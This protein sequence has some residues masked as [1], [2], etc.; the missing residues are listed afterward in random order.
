MEVEPT[1][2][3]FRKP[4]ST[5]DFILDYLRE[6]GQQYI[7]EMH[8]AYKKELDRLARENG[9]KRPYHKPRYHSFEMC[10]QLLAREGAIEFSGKEEESDNLRFIGWEFKP[11]RRF[12]RL[13]S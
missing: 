5:R 3:G 9:R 10:V 7:A 6:N 13:K 4:I 11:V 1:R 2:G 12:Y 8:R